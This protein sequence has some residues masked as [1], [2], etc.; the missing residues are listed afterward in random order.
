MFDMFDSKRARLKWNRYWF[1]IFWRWHSCR[2]ICSTDR[3]HH[4]HIFWSWFGSC[5]AITIAAYLSAKTNS[6]LIIA[7]FGATSVLIFA[8]PDS[9]LAQPRN[10]IGGN[11]LSALVSLA[12]LQL[13][14]TSPFVI[15]L[16]VSS[17]IALMQLTRT[18]HPPGGAIALVVMLT[19]PDWKFLLAPT[20]AG[21][22]IF[23]LCAVVFNNLA[24]E[25]TY[26]KHWL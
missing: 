22:I 4:H 26:P 19:Q 16:A 1:K 17:A 8:V 7:P 24:E 10:V 21:S 18:L 11:V 23:V 13:L 3:S 5:L 2:F 20:L 14:G 15:G 6:P 12:I 25:R 9:P